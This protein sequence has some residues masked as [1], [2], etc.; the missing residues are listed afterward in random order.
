MHGSQPP[1]DGRP[2]TT[3]ADRLHTSEAEPPDGAPAGPVRIERWVLDQVRERGVAG[4][5]L[6]MSVVAIAVSLVIVLASMVVLDGFSGPREF[7]VPAFAIGAIVPA[8]VAP[9]MLLYCTRLIFRLDET[10]SLLERSV[11]TDPLTGIANRRGFF[12]ALEQTRGEV[13][14]AM[15]DVDDFK[16]LN[17]RYGHSC[18][19]AALQTVATWLVDLVGEHGTVGRI[20]GDEFACVG[21]PGAL[22]IPA[23]RHHFALHDATFTVSIGVATS[24]AGDRN[25]ALLDADAALYRHKQAGTPA[26]PTSRSA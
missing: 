3:P 11:V 10:A 18:G 13:E 24:A 19:D 1:D 9:P 4:F 25:Q 2:T 6:A 26:T 8:M 16:A 14:V 15:L 22:P 12:R 7:W 20:G 5:V 21:P 23:G 17:D